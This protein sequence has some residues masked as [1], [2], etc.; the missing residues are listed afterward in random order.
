[1]ARESHPV[2]AAAE[3]LSLGG[4]WSAPE[5]LAAH[6]GSFVLRWRRLPAS[7]QIEIEH[8]QSGARA[9]VGS[10]ERALRWMREC[11]AAS[12]ES[13]ASPGDAG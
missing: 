7:E 11:L 3:G 2:H 5:T 10:A 4:A 8:V 6:Y 1:M 12:R 13:G 9:R